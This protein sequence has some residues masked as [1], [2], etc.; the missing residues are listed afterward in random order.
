ML[1]QN[2]LIGIKKSGQNLIINLKIIARKTEELRSSDKLNI[3]N[4]K[5]TH[6]KYGIKSQISFFNNTYKKNDIHICL[7]LNN[8]LIAYNCLR[9]RNINVSG[10]WHTYYLFDALI[11]HKKFR[12]KNYGS[13][14]MYFNNSFIKN[15]NKIGVLFCNKELVKFYLSNNWRKINK[16]ITNFQNNNKFIMILDF[17]KILSYKKNQKN[18]KI[19]I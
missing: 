13:L 12:S 5:N 4:L 6:W 18:I 11:I 14:M 2:I 10:L 1:I 19:L 9:R 16:K 17:K 15:N 7:F 8:R 3:C